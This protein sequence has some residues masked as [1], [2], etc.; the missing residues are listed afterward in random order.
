MKYHELPTFDMLVAYQKGNLSSSDRKWIDEM[1]HDNP[2]VKAV[3]EG[4]STISPSAVKSVSSKTNLQINSRYYTKPGFW[5]KYGVWIGLSA[6]TL[7]IGFGI[8]F[9]KNTVQKKYVAE[10]FSKNIA[11]KKSQHNK[12]LPAEKEEDEDVSVQKETEELKEDNRDLN[13]NN[14]DESVSSAQNEKLNEEEPKFIQVELPEFKEKTNNSNKDN[15]TQESTAIDPIPDA[16]EAK[17]VGQTDNT[18]TFTYAKEESVATILLAV[19]EV[20]ILAKTNPNDLK[21]TKPNKGGNPFQNTNTSSGTSG[22]YSIDDVPKFP[23]GDRALQNYFI[24]KLKPIK[25]SKGEDKYAKSIMIDLHINS[26]GK[27]KDHKIYGQIHPKHQEALIKAINNL[28]RF[29]KGSES[30]TYSLGIA[31]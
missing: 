9:Q 7:L 16:Y 17:K 25:V 24:G 5:S 10:A 22:G 3:F 21:R 19:Q 2:M 30:I 26:R 8:L 6:I 18:R 4:V 15:V 29:E 23:G 1:I 14:L 12:V 20:Q 27:L 28:P 31:F 11:I 13:Q